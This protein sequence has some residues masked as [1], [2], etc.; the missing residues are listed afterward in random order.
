M[1]LY[2]FG[3]WF[4]KIVAVL[5]TALIFLCTFFFSAH[6]DE[7]TSHLFSISKDN[8]LIA[9]LILVVFSICLLLGFNLFK[10]NTSKRLNV[11]LFITLGFT[12]LI[13]EYMAFFGRSM[14]NSDSAVVYE[15][16]KRIAAGDLSIIHPTESY[17]SYYPQQIG[18]CTFLALLIKLIHIIPVSIAEFRF[19]IAAYGVFQCVTVFFLYKTIDTMWSKPEINYCFLAL[20]FFN[21]PFIMYTSYLYGEI[22]SLMFISVGAFGLARYIKRRGNL[23]I[24]GL[25]AVIG[26]ALSVFTRKNAMIIIIAVIIVL[27][28]EALRERKIRNAILAFLIVLCSFSILPITVKAYEKASGGTLTTGVTPLSY[29]AMGMQESESGQINKG[30]Y[31]GFNFITFEESGCNP[32]IANEISKAEIKSRIETFKADPKYAFSFYKEKFMTQ[33][34]DGTYF[35]RESTYVYY[36]ARSEFLKNIYFGKW[37]FLYDYFCNYFQ[38][39]VFFGSLLWAIISV[40]RRKDGL[41]E[42]VLF[43]G[44]FGGFLFH[45]MWEANSRYIFTYACLLVPYAAAG[46]GNLISIKR[47]NK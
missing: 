5:F 4:I 46:L 19:L 30:W 16:S 40:I 37:G 41:T 9:T 45:M 32:A 36:G 33:W 28:F 13:C 34:V 31:T 35:S 44:V 10:K 21:A 2:R 20:C 11:F 27:L 14:P 15:M 7:A 3:D 29:I 39:I 1:K 47:L 12:F 38:T 6:N 8:I 17:M 23:Y 22:P 24:N 26:F 42:S 43:I 18:I 25:I